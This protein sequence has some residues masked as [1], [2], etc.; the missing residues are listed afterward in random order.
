MNRTRA[1]LAA[2]ALPLLLAL[3]AC[4]LIPVPEV[5][6][7]ETVEELVEGT[8][9]GGVDVETGEVP[10]SFPDDIPLVDG[11]VLTGVAIPGAN[12]AGESFQVTIRVADEPAAQQAAQLLRDAGFTEAPFGFSN[13]THLVVITTQA[14]PTAD[15]W[16]V[17]YLVTPNQ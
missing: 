13:A 14:D 10:A 5:N 16:T 11:E 15:G 8:T 7:D 4:S 9:G 3:G 12:G 1:T 17:A 6:L 2:L